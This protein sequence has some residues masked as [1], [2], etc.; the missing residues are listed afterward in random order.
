M[1]IPWGRAGGAKQRC[2]FA[3][4][5]PKWAQFVVPAMAHERQR[6]SLIGKVNV[7]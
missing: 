3:G 6:T 1:A 2:L 7:G 5:A 4:L